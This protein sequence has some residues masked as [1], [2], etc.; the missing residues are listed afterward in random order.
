MAVLATFNNAGFTES[1]NMDSTFLI[2]LSQTFLT[3]AGGNIGDASL[4]MSKNGSPTGFATLQIFNMTGTYGSTGLPTGS[5]LCTSDNFD[6]T[7]LTPSN[8]NFTFTFS[9]VNQIALTNAT[10]YALV[11]NYSGGDAANQIIW[12]ASTP[13][14][15]NNGYFPTPSGPWTVDTNGQDNQFTINSAVLGP[16]VSA[17]DSS[18][19]SDTPSLSIVFPSQLVLVPGILQGVRIIGP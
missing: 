17:S 7:A 14:S 10:H 5:A 8:A 18:A 9:G 1:G 4:Y 15:G 3:V 2:K 16:Q 19:M 11:L 13:Y 6:V 12:A